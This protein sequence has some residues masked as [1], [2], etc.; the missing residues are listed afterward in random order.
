MRTIG[1]TALRTIA[2][3]AAAATIVGS[4]APTA[5]AEPPPPDG[6]VLG[7]SWTATAD[8]PG[9][10]PGV[11]IDWDVPVAM[12]DGTILKVNVYRPMDSAGRIVDTPL[13]TILNMTPYT[14]LVS[15]LADSA[16]SIPVLYDTFVSLTNR[17]DL[18]DLEGTPFTGIGNQI[19]TLSSGIGR[20]FSVDRD[21]IRSGYTQV[22]ADVRGTGFSQGIWQVFAEREQQDTVEMIDWTAAQPWSNGNIGMSGVSYSGINQLKAAER[23]PP[24]LKAIFPVEPGSDLVRDV[25]APGGGVGVG[26]LPA[27]LAAVNGA[28]WLPDL[29]A[30]LQGQF[31]W[32]WLADRAASPITFIDL[33]VR[34]LFVTSVESIPEDLRTYLDPNGPFR[35]GATGHP[36]RIEVPTFLVGGWH[37]IFT[38]SEPRVFQAISLPT[39][40]KKLLMGDFYHG[41]VGSGLGTPGA[42]PRLDV[43]QRAWFDK[44]L[45]GIDNGIENYAPAT[46]FQQGGAWTTTDSYPR[47]GM[48]Y[49]RQYL[50]ARPSG[51]TGVVA[52]DGS[53]TPTPPTEPATLTVSPGL[54]TMCSQDAAQILAGV[55]GIIDGCAEDSRVSEVAALTFTGDPVEQPTEISGPVNVHLNT[56][57]DATDGY[58]SATLND[59]APDGTS[60]VLTSGQLTASLRAVDDGKSLRS[61]NGDYTDPFQFLALEQRLPV[62]PGQPT[63]LDVGLAPT[64]AVL[65]PGHRLRVDIYAA[66]FP[67]G[68]MIPALLLESQLR[69]QRLV[70]DPGAPSFVNLPSSTTL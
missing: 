60:T 4:A 33:L 67:K 59:V 21:L 70:L 46:L 49:S 28:K 24:A 51:T 27:W 30:I 65:Q 3:A 53:L 13:P 2:L 38:N 37:D 66:N 68:M 47:A 45:K 12:S 69:P 42:P 20:N 23:N 43:L 54:S 15:M 34:A 9:M 64:D 35:T 32:K 14:K 11:H 48:T 58:W 5:A 31:D 22:V 7:A 52:H 16:I 1:A 8:A 62:V 50:S 41:T 10:Y 25:V 36:D 57:L 61:P 55:L 56:V 44:W 39:E 19:R 29:A 40:Q 63:A 17:F 6:G 26:F 18:F